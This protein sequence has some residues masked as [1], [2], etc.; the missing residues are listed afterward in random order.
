VIQ[1][2]EGKQLLVP[3]ARAFKAI[4][5]DHKQILA[6]LAFDITDKGKPFIP[7]HLCLVIP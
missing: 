5:I 6:P 3:C 4:C 7:N 1:G 2:F